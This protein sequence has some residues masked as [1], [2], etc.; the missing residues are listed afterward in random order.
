MKTTF[1][2]ILF[3]AAD[4]VAGQSDSLQA[5]AYVSMAKA[6]IKQQK[7]DSANIYH[8]RALKVFKENNWL[9]PWLK[10]YSAL[11]YSMS[12]DMKQPFQAVELVE[13]SL[14]EK[15]RMPASKKEWEQLAMNLLA[16]GHILNK[17]VADLNGAKKYYE[18]ADDIFRKNLDENCDR[19]AVYLYHNLANIYTRHGDYERAI[20]LLYRSIEYNRTHPEAKVVD[21]GDLAIALNETGKY[22]DALDVVR[23]GYAIE[24]LSS[25]VKISLSQNEADALFKLGNTTAALA[26]LDKIPGLI[27]KMVKEKGPLDEQQYFMGYYASR[28]EILAALGNPALA[29]SHYLKAIKEGSEYYGTNHRREIGKI[30]GNLGSMKLTQ[31]K[32]QDALSY[33]HQGLQ[34]VVSGFETPDHTQLPDPKNFINENTILEGLEGKAR[35]FA[36]LGQLENA[37]ACYE[38][39]PIVEAKLRATYAYESSSLLALSESRSRFDQAVSLAWTLFERSNGQRSFADRA[40]R[41]TEQARGMLLLQSLAQAQ[42]KYQLPEPLRQ[43]EAAL[44]AKITWYELET[45]TEAGAAG[46]AARLA[47]LQKELFEI[48]QAFEKFKAELRQNYAAYAALSEEIQFLESAEVPAL[49]RQN[50][51]FIDF[52]L[53][54][55]EAYIFAFDEKGNFSWRKAMLPEGFRDA[56][57][58]FAEYLA[59]GDEEDKNG[60]SSFRHNASAWFELLLAPELQR[61]MPVSGSLI[62]VPD[63]AL[64]FVPFE[65]L[66]RQAAP[67]GNWRDLPWL[68]NNYSTS[69]AYSA[70]LLKMQQTISQKHRERQE[71]TRYVFGGF[72]PTYSA[73]GVYKLSSTEPLVKSAQRLLG[74]KTWCGSQASEAAFKDIAPQCRLLLLAMHGLADAEKPEL[75]RLLFG[76]P[77]ADS[78]ENDNVLYASE[79][80]IM[81]LQADLAVLSACHSGFGK[82]QKGEGV[83]SL[84]RAF[85]RAGVP[86]TIM[87]MWLLHENTAGP[88]V[89]AFLQYLQAGKTKDEALRLAKLDFL[90]ND[91]N[92]EMTHPFYWAGVMASGDMCALDIQQ[93]TQLWWYWAIGIAALLGGWLLFQRSRKPSV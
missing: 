56:V 46:D 88:L 74:G 86:A 70:T 81:Q 24:G 26:A 9:A 16:A 23:Q 52:Y 54:A 40:F 59:K 76:D 25:Q 90:K 11:A 30:F 78:L 10:S 80:Q 41:L 17:K 31:K 68:L 35:A 37:L 60:A 72:A 89:Q 34:C 13:K 38:L 61:L 51:A 57:T 44:K 1:F 47:Q 7:T 53:T 77:L 73:S 18:A 27:L 36:G 14:G 42:A 64:V 84:A 12:G 49:L 50:Q 75:S 69:Y 92:F 63:D 71:A 79:L 4:I 32:Y 6:A 28:A 5:E 66:L 48:K 2:L 33:F 22:K 62:I 65:V 82:L 20:R 67:T 15:W 55:S 93:K 3:L 21:H 8:H 43:R 39:I 19:I 45:A 87:S 83:F 29:E 91:Q 85:A 58:Q